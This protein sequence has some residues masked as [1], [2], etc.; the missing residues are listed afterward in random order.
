MIQALCAL[1]VP[2]NV[3]L[4]G[5]IS[6]DDLASTLDLNKERLTHLIR[7]AITC[8][9]YLAESHDG[10]VKHSAMSAIWHL[11]PTMANGM[12]VMMDNLP[13]SSFHIAQCVQKDPHGTD[14][15]VCPFSVARDKPLFQWFEDN[16]EQG[17]KFA[18]HMRA[19]SSKGGDEAVRN[20]YDWS[21]LAGKTLVDVS[22]SRNMWRTYTDLYIQLGG[23]FGS[24]GAAILT[25]EPNITV[26]VQDLPK[27]IESAKAAASKANQ[28]LPPNLSFAAHSFLEPQPVIAD[29]YL[30]RMVFHNWSDAGAR[31]ILEALKPAL[32]PGARVI[33]IEY[34]M[35]KMGSAPSYAELQ[36]RRLDNVMYTLM[37]GKVRELEEFQ[38]L[39]AEVEPR[40]R[41]NH[42]KPGQPKATHDPRSHSVMEWIFEEEG[43]I[44]GDKESDGVD[45]TYIDTET[46]NGTVNGRRIHND[47]EVHDASLAK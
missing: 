27:V 17:R 40:L 9:D 3:P 8:S 10:K 22:P 37:N 36:T 21:K 18:S 14:D 24:V 33:L 32:R 31:R 19:Q 26:I 28:P 20:G 34:V 35:P 47:N 46:T 7:N 25:K 44:G 23:S 4:Y 45:M 6:Y 2:Q 16:P 39:F 41:F 43:M 1:Q 12:E 13:L 42:F 15:S 30:Y 38:T 5:S 11:D 29:V